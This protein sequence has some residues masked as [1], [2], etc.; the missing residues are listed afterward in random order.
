MLINI[1]FFYIVPLLISITKCSNHSM[2]SESESHSSGS[3]S[4]NEIETDEECLMD[5]L[6]E[7]DTIQ[8]FSL[9][10]RVEVSDD[11]R[12]QE[13]SMQGYG[14][15]DTDE[16]D[17]KKVEERRLVDKDL[18]CRCGNCSLLGTEIECYCCQESSHISNL[19]LDKE[20]LTCVTECELFTNTIGNQKVLEMCSFGM[21]QKRMHVNSEGKIIPEGL[22][23]AAYRN[24]LS[25]CELRFIGKNKRYALPACV[26]TKIRSL[27][28][29]PNGKYKAFKISEFSSRG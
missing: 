3:E 17:D 7:A 28:P 26:V 21:L 16:E 1:F 13:L 12:D 25:I 14:S 15:C 22:R 18:W 10:P 2:Q 6:P 4:G 27:Y 9:D 8:D 20:R 11:D 5:T 29:S 19:I 23:Y 24:F